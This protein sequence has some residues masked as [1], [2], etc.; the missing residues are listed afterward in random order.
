MSFRIERS[1]SEDGIILRVMGR[2][3]L[4]NL[5]ELKA[6]LANTQPQI[7]FDLEGVTLVDSD[8]VRFLLACETT[9]IG[10]VRCSLYVREWIRR[11]QERQE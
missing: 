1:S 11:E 9:G 2:L 8:V 4:E 7:V 10:V 3:R 6:Q 5:E